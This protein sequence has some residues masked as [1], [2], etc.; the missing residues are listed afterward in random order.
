MQDDLPREDV[1]AVVDQMVDELLEAAG[2]KEPP[3]DAI[4]LAQRHL[5][6][7]GRWRTRSA[8]TSRSSCCNVLASSRARRAA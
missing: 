4:A 7:S 5:G 3:V 8:S 1:S 6:I 2:V